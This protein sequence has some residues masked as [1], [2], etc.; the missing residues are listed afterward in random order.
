MQQ[1][2]ELKQELKRMREICDNAI[3]ISS[4]PHISN[5]KKKKIPEIITISDA[6][7]SSKKEKKSIEQRNQKNTQLQ[8]DV[9]DLSKEKLKEAPAP[10]KSQNWLAFKAKVTFFLI[11]S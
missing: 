4:D 7:H 3:I 2:N 10:I 5:P 8:K 11:L 6:S 1:T 9:I